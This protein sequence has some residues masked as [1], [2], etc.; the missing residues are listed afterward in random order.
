[1]GT[2][3]CFFQRPN[4][5]HKLCSKELLR[6]SFPWLISTD[7]WRRNSDFSTGKLTVCSES[8]ELSLSPD[9]LSV[10]GLSDW[11][12]YL[13]GDFLRNDNRPKLPEKLNWCERRGKDLCAGRVGWEPVKGG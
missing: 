6:A 3:A 7:L 8:P 4:P 1:M 12:K 5:D 13:L 9:P 11:T 2:A 10:Y